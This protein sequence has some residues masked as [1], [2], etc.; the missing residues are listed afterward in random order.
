[1]YQYQKLDLVRSVK[2]VLMIKIKA[3]M[4]KFLYCEVFA[5]LP[6]YVQ[7][8][9]TIPTYVCKYVATK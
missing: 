5:T 6:T 7:Y 9:L 1:M 2:Y 4:F 8:V 3:S